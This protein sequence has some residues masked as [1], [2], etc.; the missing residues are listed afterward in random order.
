[1]LAEDAG[2]AVLTVEDSGP[3]VRPELLPHVFELFSGNTAAGEPGGLGIGLALVR[4][5]VELHGGSVQA[6]NRGP[7]GGARF[8]GLLPA[9]PPPEPVAPHDARPLPAPR[10]A[11]QARV[12]IVEDNDDSRV[13]LQRILQA[14]G[15][16]VSAARDAGAGLEAAAAGSP[17]IALV[18]I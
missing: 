7:E 16:L 18:D 8:T 6:G 12:L 2:E 4:R 1:R 13:T 5:L 15:H 3:G 14:D 9:V 11:R 10:P 17:N